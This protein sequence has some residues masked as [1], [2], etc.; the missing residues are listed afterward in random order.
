LGQLTGGFSC[1]PGPGSST[2]TGAHQLPGGGAGGLLPGNNAI[3]G[4]NGVGATFSTAAQ[5]GKGYGAGGG[6]GGQ[7][8]TSSG[9]GGQGSPGVVIMTFWCGVDLR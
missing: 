6:G 4:S 5:G 9:Q 2:T 8:S 7:G 1:F 3:S